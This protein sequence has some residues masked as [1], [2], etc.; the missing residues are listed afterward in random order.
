MSGAEWNY[1]RNCFNHSVAAWS[2]VKL[3]IGIGGDFKP[4]RIFMM[5]FER[6]GLHTIAI[7]E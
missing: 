2:F 1:F 6:P 3:F 4:N 5:N 7:A